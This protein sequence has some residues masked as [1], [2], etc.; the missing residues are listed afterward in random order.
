MY[1]KIRSKQEIRLED[2]YLC[3]SNQS[4]FMESQMKY[5]H[6]FLFLVSLAQASDI[7]ILCDYPPPDTECGVTNRCQ[8]IEA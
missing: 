6:I 3:L 1:I 5:L 8:E 2:T 7:Y 4:K